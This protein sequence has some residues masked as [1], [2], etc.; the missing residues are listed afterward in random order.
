MR[1]TRSLQFGTGE[2]TDPFATT[3]RL[4]AKGFIKIPLAEDIQ[5]PQELI[6]EWFSI[7]QKDFANAEFA[8]K[9]KQPDYYASVSDEVRNNIITGTYMLTTPS[10]DGFIYRGPWDFVLQ[11]R[12]EDYRMKQ[13]AGLLNSMVMTGDALMSAAR[14]E[15]VALNRTKFQEIL[16]TKGHLLSQ[17]EKIK[18]EKFFLYQFDQP[19]TA[20]EVAEVQA[21][22]DRIYKVEG[23]MN[24]NVSIMPVKD[25][26][27]LF[28]GLVNT[29]DWETQSAVQKNEV[30]IKDA[31]LVSP[32]ETA[33]LQAGKDI[34][35]DVKYMTTGS[36]TS[37]GEEAG[38]K[39]M[40]LWIGLGI[41]ALKLIRR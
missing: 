32:L 27:P 37:T 33:F 11:R 6:N 8:F 7:W 38:G 9:S 5:V 36:S 19:S 31:A 13:Q 34:Q 29:T 15:V 22:L 20:Q 41:L 14:R 2:Q 4:L 30:L 23:N 1:L 35:E 24:N 17:D 12:I 18:L 40:L 28:P 10:V 21:I 25:T 26:L 16:N 3:N 39:N